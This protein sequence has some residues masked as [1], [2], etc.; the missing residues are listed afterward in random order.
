MATEQ[1][2]KT[3]LVGAFERGAGGRS[4]EGGTAEAIE[5]AFGPIIREHLSVWEDVKDRVLEKVEKMGAHSAVIARASVIS[6]E[7]VRTAVRVVCVLAPT[8]ICRLVLGHIGG[9]PDLPE[10]EWPGGG[11]PPSV[12]M[13]RA[14][15]KPTP[16]TGARK[17]VGGRKRL[18]KAPKRSR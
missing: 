12:G 2:I 8:W 1:Q 5:T 17:A 14:A 9:F 16:R 13:R 3:A 11:I 10:H 6:R 7:D 4:A 15:R 18:G